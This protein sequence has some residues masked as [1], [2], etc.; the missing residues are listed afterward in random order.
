MTAHK[1]NSCQ[2]FAICEDPVSSFVVTKPR[3]KCSNRNRNRN[4]TQQKQPQKI[5][6]EYPSVLSATGII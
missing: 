1:D 5:D 3:Y 4:R 2:L 6:P